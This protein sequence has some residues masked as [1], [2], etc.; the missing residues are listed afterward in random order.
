MAKNSIPDFSATAASNTDIQSVNID[1]NCPA[2]GIN[3][4]IRELMADLKNMDTGAVALT[5]PQFTTASMAGNLTLGDNAKA[6]FG[7]GNDL[8][9]YHNG[10]TS[11][12]EDVGTGN[13]LITTN[14]NNIQLMKQQSEQML[15]AKPD[16]AVELYYDN[17]KK[18]ETTSTGINI[19]GSAG[20]TLKLTSTDTS[21]A[22][23]E[24]LGQIDFVSSDS[25]TGS[26]GTQARIKGVYEDNG[27][28][29]GIAFF[30]GAS[31]GSGT[32]T[33]S[34]VMRIRHEGNVGIGTAAPTSTFRTSIKGDY[35]SII[36]GIEFDSG[37]GDKFTVGHASATSPSGKINVVGAGSLV[38]ATNNTE[39][40]RVDANGVFMVGKSTASFDNVGFQ[41]T[42]DGQAAF[43]RDGSQALYVNRQTTDGPIVELRQDNDA[44]LLL[45]SK[46]TG[47]GY[48]STNVANSTGLRFD[49]NFIAP[50]DGTGANRD[51][52]IDL[53]SS[54]ARFDDIHATNS[55]IQ[56]SD[57]N[58]K[59][60]I[61]SL[62]SAEI[63]AAKSISKLFKTFKWKDK[64]AAKGDAART[65]TGV[66]AQEVQAAMATAG[67][68]ATN[69]AFWCSDTWTNDDG[70]KQTRMGVRY[71]ELLAFVGAATE[72]RLADIENRLAALE[73]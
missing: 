27:D 71:P 33:I 35:S 9:I 40:T 4:A 38:S 41:V 60:N 23:T 7:A 25:S 21:G 30:T 20:A 22:D 10:A 50:C 14:G 19:Q 17:V 58:E 49:T 3:N 6:I 69:Y 39:R 36:G 1:E 55:T 12:I 5:S 31:T 28:S 53:G 42:Q 61:A 47:R 64:V 57:Q 32:P 68:D 51:N 11:F 37:G 15:V 63:T 45:G 43:T 29:S 48:I 56:T 54:G 13:F 8:Q 46:F 18:L 2:S 44:Q 26:A 67:L 65:H 24:L 73:A 72:Q 62:T 34:E 16:D 59:Q 70:S 66:I 52:V